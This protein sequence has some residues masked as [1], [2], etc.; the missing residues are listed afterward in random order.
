VYNRERAVC[1]LREL[2]PKRER[3]QGRR[4]EDVD[5]GRENPGAGGVEGV[6]ACVCVRVCV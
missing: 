2:L 1:V 5:R 6:C 3:R 4:E